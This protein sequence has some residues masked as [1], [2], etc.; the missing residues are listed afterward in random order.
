M[1]ILIVGGG[2]GG[3]A[4]AIALARAGHGITLVERQPQFSPLG[5]GIV[6]AP[7]AARALASL[8]VDIAPVADTLPSMTITR[9]D[10]RVLQRLDTRG[11]REGWGPSWALTRAALGGALAGALP[12]RVEVLLGREVARLDEVRQGVEVTLEGESS[13]R[14]VD[15]VVGADGLRSA[16]RRLVVGE[17]PIRYSGVT[18]W[19]GLTAN[20]GFNAAVEAWG[21]RA[22]AGAVPLRG[23]QLYYFLVLT[24][25][26]R[27]PAPSWPSGFRDAFGSFEPRFTRLLEQLDAAPLL[28]H[29]IEELERPV[30]GR[31]RVL[32]MG[33]AAH[34]MTPNQGQGAAMA[35]EDAL[36]LERVLAA[37]VKRALERYQAL[38]AGRVRALQLESRR[39]GDVAHWRAPLA[40]ALRDALF[41]AL[42]AAA[43][44]A[45]L[46]R[47]I[48]PGLALLGG[49]PR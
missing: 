31:G 34:A 15:L 9:E 45:Q 28:H 23:G 39:I 5:A 22:R 49:P 33:D 18:C 21:G 30:W 13:A 37:G 11:E 10:G 46:A 32:L 35:I 25:P 16:V 14:R 41:R 20:P 29:D 17:W 26:R 4:A 40:R 44:R 3:L 43:G 12:A 38:R 19:R 1:N 27:A 24:A 47:L 36:A 6:L 8:G 42:P 2:I 7:N 48:R